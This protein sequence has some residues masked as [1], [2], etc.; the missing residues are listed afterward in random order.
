M[1]GLFQ[2][3]GVF[4]TSGPESLAFV[5]AKQGYDVWLGNNRCVERKHMN[6]KPHQLEFWDWSLDELAKFDFPALVD[7]VL[8]VTGYSKLAYI[9][10]SQ[11]TSQVILSKLL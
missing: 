7:Y 8:K 11:G 4:V 6:L 2:S 1:H 3:G 10:H 9:G 5:L